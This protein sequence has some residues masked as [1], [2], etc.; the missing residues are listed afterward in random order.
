MTKPSTELL[1]AIVDSYE[2][3]GGGWGVMHVVIE[4]GNY[5]KANIEACRKL[6]EEEADQDAIFI[7]D[8]LALY[9]EDELMEFL[10]D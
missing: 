6:A 3:M 4:D 2:R 7:A 8:L 5:D 10:G 9:T 1:K